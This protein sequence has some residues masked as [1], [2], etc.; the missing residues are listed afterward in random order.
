MHEDSE[1]DRSGG[2]AHILASYDHESSVFMAGLS[3]GL[4]GSGAVNTVSASGNQSVAS[5]PLALEN[6]VRRGTSAGGAANT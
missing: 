5:P 6:R 4:R 3:L 2:A 1:E